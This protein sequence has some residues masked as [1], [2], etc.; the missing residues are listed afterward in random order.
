MTRLSVAV[1]TL[2]PVGWWPLG[3]GTLASALVAPLWL[4]PVPWAAWLAVVGA[5]MVGGTAAADRAETVLGHDDGRIVI[6]EV[7]GMGLALLATPRTWAGVGIAFLLFRFLDIAKPPP[8][9]R[10]QRVRGGWGVMLDDV[11]AGVLAAG[12]IA[13]GRW[14]IG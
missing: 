13:L 2:G 7:V 10:L 6:D 8:V 14:W 3:P 1:A 12:L 5:A 11:A 4:L 9:G